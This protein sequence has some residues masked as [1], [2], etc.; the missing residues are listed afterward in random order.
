MLFLSLFFLIKA[1]NTLFTTRWTD[2]SHAAWH[3]PPRTVLRS[4]NRAKN[5]IWNVHTRFKKC[6]IHS[7][8]SIPII[9]ISM[10]ICKLSVIAYNVWVISLQIYF[11]IKLLSIFLFVPYILYLKILAL[12]DIWEDYLRYR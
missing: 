10:V 8:I 6:S 9:S 12:M 5:T 7:L 1:I 3:E 2:L 11:L 4:I